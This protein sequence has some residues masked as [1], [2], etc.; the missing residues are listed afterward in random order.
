VTGDAEEGEG[1]GG[2]RGGGDSG[3]AEQLHDAA[4]AQHVAARGRR[5]VFMLVVQVTRAHRRVRLG[6]SA[7]ES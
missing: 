4:A 3:R 1:H 2:H 7:N 6:V 5:L